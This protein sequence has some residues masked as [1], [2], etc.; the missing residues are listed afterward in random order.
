MDYPKQAE[1]NQPELSG[2]GSRT[3]FALIILAVILAVSAY[4]A[5]SF[6]GTTTAVDPGVTPGPAPME[7][8]Q[9]AQ[10]PPQ[11][12]PQPTPAP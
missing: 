5:I 1:T 11:P 10:P 7:Q 6:W 2:E 8:S 9:P 3:I 12:Q 4:C